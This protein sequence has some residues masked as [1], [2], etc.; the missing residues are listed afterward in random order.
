MEYKKSNTLKQK[1]LKYMIKKMTLKEERD[2]H[3]A[4]MAAAGV[5]EYENPFPK[6]QEYQKN[7]KN[8]QK[9]TFNIPAKVGKA[10][11]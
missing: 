10:N 5:S 1:P 8:Y 7:M 11:K 3:Y 4:C 9:D 2:L 6:E